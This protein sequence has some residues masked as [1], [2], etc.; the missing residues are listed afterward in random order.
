MTFFTIPNK[1][2]NRS[3]SNSVNIVRRIGKCKIF[4]TKR[5]ES[6]EKR[7]ST[8][9]DCEK[10][11]RN[12]HLLCVVRKIQSHEQ[13]L[14]SSYFIFAFSGLLPFSMGEKPNGL[15]SFCNPNFKLID[16]S[17]NRW[18]RVQCLWRQWPRRYLVGI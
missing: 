14:L 15:L 10:D 17:G 4:W 1:K 5:R 18:F 2:K 9:Q 11:R 13:S 7:A 8:W 16:S 12:V 3:S 6:E